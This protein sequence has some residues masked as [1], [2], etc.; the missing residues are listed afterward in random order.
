[1]LG[2]YFDDFV[3]GEKPVSAGRTIG[4]STIDMFAS[5]TSDFSDAHMDAEVMKEGKWVF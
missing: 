2:K 4:K 3:V 5:L 1:M